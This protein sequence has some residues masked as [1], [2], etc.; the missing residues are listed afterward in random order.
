MKKMNKVYLIAILTLLANY[1]FAQVPSPA[2]VR[3]KLN[4]EPGYTPRAALIW[5]VDQSSLID[6]Y[7][8]FL[9]GEVYECMSCG[10]F[11][12]YVYFGTYYSQNG[13][14][15]ENVYHNCGVSA[16][17]ING[18]S[19]DTITFNFYF[20]ETAYS[21]PSNL[22]IVNNL[23]ESQAYFY[24]D[25]P[26]FGNGPNQPFVIGYSVLL[27]GIWLDDTDNNEFTFTGLTLNK[28]YVAGLV[29]RY[30]DGHSDSTFY[31]NYSKKEFYFG[32]LPK[33]VELSVNEAGGIVSWKVPNN[34]G[35]FIGGTLNAFELSMDWNWCNTQDFWLKIGDVDDDIFVNSKFSFNN[36]I[37]NHAEAG[38]D[39]EAIS[40]GHIFI[41]NPPPYKYASVEGRN[42]NEITQN[43]TFSF[44]APLR[45]NNDAETNGGTGSMVVHYNEDNGIYGVVRVDDLYNLHFDEYD[46]PWFSL[47]LTWWIKTEGGHD[48]SE[49]FNY[50]PK[51]YLVYLDDVFVDTVRSTCE[52]FNNTNFIY[53]LQNL[54][55]GNSYTLGLVAEYNVGKSQLET[56]DF[57][58]SGTGIDFSVEEIVSP[59][60]GA[61]LGYEEITI[62]VKNNGTASQSDIPVN[63]MINGTTVVNE[64]ISDPVG[65]EET[66]EYTFSELANLSSPSTIYTIE[67][68]TALLEDE[69][70]ENNCLS[71][72]VT[73]TSVADPEINITPGSISQMLEPGTTGSRSI[74]IEN[75]GDATLN[76]NLDINPATRSKSGLCAENLY[77]GGCMDGDGLKY[78]GFANIIIPEIPCSGDPSWYHD[79][80]GMNH[81]L[82]PGETYQ[83]SVISGNYDAFLDVWIDFNDDFELTNDE[84]VMNNGSL[85]NKNTYYYF[86][87]TIPSTAPI[88]NHV[89]RARTNAWSPVT[90][91]CATYDMGNCCD[92][93]ATIGGSSNEWLSA[94]ITSGTVL[95]G[96]SQEI[97]LTFNAQNLEEGTYENT[98]MVS[99]N[100]PVN[101][102]VE[103]PV[104]LQVTTQIQPWNF[105]VTG[106]VHTISV[107]NAA[108]PNIYGEPLVPG[109]WIGVFYS[110]DDG[111]KV[112]GGA[113]M[114]DAQGKAV[115]MAY[116]DDPTTAT[117]DGFE[118]GEVFR[119]KLYDA[120]TQSSYNADAMYDQNM[121]NQDEFANL[122]LSK[123]TGLATQLCQDYILEEGWNSLSS[124]I[125]PSVPA[126]EEMFAPVV[127]NLI[128]LQNLTSVYWPVEGINTIGNFDNAS[129]YAI[130]MAQG[131]E[132]SICGPSFAGRE[133]ALTEGWHYMPV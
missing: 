77:G 107:P 68:C 90:D 125:V 122:G 121:P 48:F 129:G 99:S 110:D 66:I 108:N 18:Q 27:D 30:S 54:E 19:S 113:A 34:S 5:D 52:T 71:I 46:I 114:I 91:P 85:P 33:V 126:V 41:E 1:L 79:F 45:G 74:A 50:Y 111:N 118:S 12:G 84:V 24:W 83:L 23:D 55:Q 6:H 100:D 69:V 63:Y 119:W 127:D 14:F 7:E 57:T 21:R 25:S 56:M 92:F 39:S 115:V 10:N 130:K 132:M 81:D 59:V 106:L 31:P 101:P 88:G 17:D 87:I 60:S 28:N 67:A 43:S 103:V 80:T 11:D 82:Q 96:E 8:V 36:W 105:I 15:E 29:T 37:H 97:N 3:M 109:D 53:Q 44:V 93:T 42:I 40:F 89:M 22:R 75:N 26:P 112:C 47:D 4:F 58:F 32:T 95:P 128:I 13:P 104:T 117:K 76:F 38:D 94:D 51:W 35:Y 16:V 131:T 72:E 124:Y 65:P 9:D 86:N 62:V 120:S 64:I 20:S 102:V 123:L 73:N 70:P 49:A 78:W 61:N 2:N 133:L 98:I 116:G